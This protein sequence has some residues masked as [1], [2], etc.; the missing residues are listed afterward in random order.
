[1]RDDSSNDQTPN[2][3]EDPNHKLQTP[4]KLQGPSSNARVPAKLLGVGAWS[5]SGSWSL[6]FGVSADVTHVTM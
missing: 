5:F 4:E 3:G 2:P 1:M 6:G